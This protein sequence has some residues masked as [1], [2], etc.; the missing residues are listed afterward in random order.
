[1]HSATV[2]SIDSLNGS[3][4][5]EDLTWLFDQGFPGLD[6]EHAAT[7]EASLMLALRPE[8]VR[9][10]EVLDEEHPWYDL[11]PEPR[12]HVPASGALSRASPASAAK[13]ERLRD[14]LI[15]RLVEA[16]VKESGAVREGPGRMSQAAGA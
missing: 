11:V 2:M 8:L 1:M 15:P 6:V 9:I 14:M 4:I 12:K 16:I 13:G 7:V 5:H 3:L 10:D